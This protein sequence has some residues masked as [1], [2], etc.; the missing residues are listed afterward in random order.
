MGKKTDRII[1]HYLYAECS[2]ITG[3]VVW[4]FY[5]KFRY[6][7]LLSKVNAAKRQAHKRAVAAEKKRWQQ[8]PETD[9]IRKQSILRKINDCLADIPADKSLSPEQR[10]MVNEL[11]KLSVEN[12]GGSSEFYEHIME[13]ERRAAMVKKN[14]K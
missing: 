2:C 6:G 9:A 10:K 12:I 13:K 7:R 14:K 1:Y 3:R 5:R 8:M 11:R 4:V